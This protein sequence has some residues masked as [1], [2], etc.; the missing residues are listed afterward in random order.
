MTW[1]ENGFNLQQIAL[2]AHN[3]DFALNLNDGSVRFVSVSQTI[4]TLPFREYEVSYWIGNS[5]ANDG[6]ASVD[7]TITDGTS[8]TIIFSETGTAPRPP[9]QHGCARAS[10]SSRTA[11]R[12]RSDSRKASAEPTSGLDDVNVIGVPE[13]A[14]WAMMLAGFAGLGLAGCRR[15]RKNVYA[16]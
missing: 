6:P 2:T 16:T 10:N 11:R 14:T 4:T 9:R 12:T 7:A 3:G 5:S 13:P 8:N 15:S 1:Y